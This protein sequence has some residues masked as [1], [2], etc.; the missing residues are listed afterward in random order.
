MRTLIVSEDITLDGV[1][2]SPDRWSAPFQCD[3]MAEFLRRQMQE[4]D[5]LLLGRATYQE[6]AG[7]WPFQSNDASGVAAYINKVAKFVVSSTLEQADWQ[8]TTIIGGNAAEQIAK[9]KA[10]PG[11]S[12]VVT[13]SAVLAQS[14]MK[15]HLIDEYRLFV[16]PVVIGQGKHLFPDGSDMQP[17]KLAEVKPF[18][19]GVVLLIYKRA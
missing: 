17:L 10:Q 19:S 2:G 11:K 15:H 14:L 5:A 3:D 8:N 18:S 6:F 7:Y 13:G 12:I 4:A 1:V 16:A 9:L